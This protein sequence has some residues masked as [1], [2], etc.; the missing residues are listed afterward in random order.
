MA[1]PS[2]PA[3]PS[4][5]VMQAEDIRAAQKGG[6]KVA[7]S[8]SAV[9]AGSIFNLPWVFPPGK[10][11]YKI[12]SKVYIVAMFMGLSACLMLLVLL[13]IH[14]RAPKAV[15]IA[16]KLMWV[17]LALVQSAVALGI[18]IVLMLD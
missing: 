12:L 14:P 2:L 13:V 11:T 3:L 4:S 7:I 16:K 15:Y 10:P 8:T 9:A 18:Y 1:D 5:P 6:F 17:A